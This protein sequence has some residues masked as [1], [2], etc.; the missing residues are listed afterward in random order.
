MTKEEELESISNEILFL[1][2]KKVNDGLVEIH[3]PFFQVKG[4]VALLTMIITIAFSSFG[5]LGTFYLANR[6]RIILWII[7]G[8]LSLTAI[9][10]TYITS[11]K[12]LLK[13]RHKKIE[14]QIEELKIKYAEIKGNR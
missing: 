3:L 2:R 8:L 12:M 13:K 10:I 9:F 14:K 11:R 6:S 1:K 7:I 5:L 4:G